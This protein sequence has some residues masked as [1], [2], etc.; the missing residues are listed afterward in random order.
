MLSKINL[1][2]HNGKAPSP[3]LPTSCPTICN[4]IMT[5]IISGLVSPPDHVYISIFDL[6]SVFVVR[7]SILCSTWGLL[8]SLSTLLTDE[9]LYHLCATCL[10]PSAAMLEIL[11]LSCGDVESNPGPTYDY[12]DKN[13]STWGGG[14]NVRLGSQ[15]FQWLFYLSPIISAGKLCPR[16]KEIWKMCATLL[17]NDLR[18]KILK[19]VSFTPPPSPPPQL[20]LTTYSGVALFCFYEPLLTNFQISVLFINV[21]I[22]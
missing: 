7:K 20:N 19:I 17:E 22:L 12:T 1:K 16:L 14:G 15:F 9:L 11:L 21:F 13:V 4:M 8:P 3:T 2:C 5:A 10:A 6:K 18:P